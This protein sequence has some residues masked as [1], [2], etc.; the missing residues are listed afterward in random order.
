[1]LQDIINIVVKH[2]EGFWHG[3]VVTFEISVLVWVLGIAIGAFLGILS[4]RFKIASFITETVSFLLSGVP[5]LVFLFWLHYPAQK[6]IGLNVHPFITTVFMLTVLNS[7][8][9]AEI[10][11]SGIT[12]LPKQ[13]VEVAKVCGLSPKKTFLKIELPLIIRHILPALL[14]T[15]VNMLHM[16]LFGSLIS[17]EEIFRVSQRVIAEEYKPVE[18]YTA[19]GIFFLVISLPINGVALYLRKRFRKLDEK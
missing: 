1:M 9:V 6:F 2:K 19:L 4:S 12:N 7:V 8:S 13:F 5:I 11:K 15:Q 18:V 3:L 17:V 16:T 10:L 14:V